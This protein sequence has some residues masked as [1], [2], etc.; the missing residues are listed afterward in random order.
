M[1][2][3]PQLRDQLRV[4]QRPRRRR[5]SRWGWLYLTLLVVLIWGGFSAPAQSQ[6]TLL[7]TNSTAPVVVNGRKVLEVQGVGN[8]TAAKRAQ[9]INERLQE[10]VKLSQPTEIEV[11]VE[12][13]KPV[14]LR[15]RY[16]GNTL[17]TVTEA[18]LRTPSYSLARQAEDWAKILQP[19]LRR[20]QGELRPAYF[21][22]ALIYSLVALGVAIALHIALR[23][24]SRRSSRL[25]NRWFT[26]PANPLIVWESPIKFFWQLGL[27]GLKV[28]LWLFTLVYLTGLFPQ[29]RIWRH[30]I[31]TLLTIESITLGDQKY[32]ALSLVILLG[33]TI[34]LWFAARMIAQLFRVYIL[35]RARVESRL[36]DIIGILVQYSLLFLGLIVLLQTFGI[37]VS[38]LT[39]LASVLGVGIGFGVQNIANNFISGFIITLERPIQ[40]GDFIKIGDLVGIVKQVGARSTEINTLDKVTIIVPNS[41][42]LESE[43]INW[44]HGDPISRLRVPVGVAYGSDIARVKT[45]L[46]EAVK[47]HP[48]VLLRPEPEVWFQSFGDS[49]LNFEIMAWTGDP[50]KQFRVKSDLNY[51]IEAS[52]RHY[53]LEV[54]FPQCDMNLRSPQLDELLA[55]L[56]QQAIGVSSPYLTTL[57]SESL[58][59]RVPTPPVVSPNNMPGDPTANQSPEQT[60]DQTAPLPDLLANLDVEA[61]AEAMRGPQ[62]I[63]LQPIPDQ[64]DVPSTYFTGKAVLEWLQQKRDYNHTGAMLVAQWLLQKGLLY[65]LTDDRDFEDS[66][67]DSQALYQFYQ[68]SPAAQAKSIESPSSPVIPDKDATEIYSPEAD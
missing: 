17:A 40:V 62:G 12:E 43:V 18:D 20:G 48:E 30:T 68:D 44:S 52:L 26:S 36:Q 14:L 19:A 32:S 49:S 31:Y 28:G 38:S 56:K 33:L 46:L 9:N 3:R 67:E 39:I 64:P 6:L 7:N 29:I 13:D 60:T 21:Q 61:L 59:S 42:F 45:A 65:A 47:R 2:L 22:R 54:P 27:L 57:P 66:F 51:A 25:L 53:G 58:S 15:S 10:E 55:I 5:A 1:P 34:S 35:E 37:D 11:V 41:R 8:F 50:R 63:T 23:T 16:S 24:F 4:P